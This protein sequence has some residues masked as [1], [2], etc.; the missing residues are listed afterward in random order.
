MPRRLIV[1]RDKRTLGGLF[2]TALFFEKSHRGIKLRK[3]PVLPARRGQTKAIK[4]FLRQRLYGFPVSV[5]GKLPYQI[6]VY[7]AIEIHIVPM[8]LVPMPGRTDAVVVLTQFGGIFRLA[9]HTNKFRALKAERGKYL[10][11]NPVHEVVGAKRFVL[12]H[13]GE[14]QQEGAHGFYIHIKREKSLYCGRRL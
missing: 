12:R 1:G 5:A 4:Q 3:M 13:I 7:I 11:G 2:L 10:A 14:A 9:F 6:V 8:L